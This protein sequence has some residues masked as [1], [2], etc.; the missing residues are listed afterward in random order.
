[1][2]I[3]NLENNG[4]SGDI[5]DFLGDLPL[6]VLRLGGNDW[7]AGTIDFVYG[8]TTLEDLRIYDA[9]RNGSVDAAIG[10]LVNLQRLELYSNQ[11]EEELPEEIGACEAMTYLDIE[12]NSFSGPIPASIGNLAN[13]EEFYLSGNNFE[14][15]IPDEI[16]AIE[17]LVFLVPDCSIE[18]AEGCC[19][20]CNNVDQA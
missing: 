6:T 4:L 2:D 7:N 15:A 16:C 13:L 8:M 3:L 1:M 19:S 12:F 17:A 10:N 5:P 20:N 9:N 18:C 11:L 14:G